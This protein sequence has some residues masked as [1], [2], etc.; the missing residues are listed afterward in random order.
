VVVDINTPLVIKGFYGLYMAIATAIWFCFLSLILTHKNV[1]QF[2]KTN[3][4]IFDRVMG[5]VMIGLALNILIG[6]FLL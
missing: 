4:H 3:A 6:E 2:F 1:Q 5:A